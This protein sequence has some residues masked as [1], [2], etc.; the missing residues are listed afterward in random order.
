MCT[1]FLSCDYCVV[2]DCS[3][4]LEFWRKRGSE[5]IVWSMGEEE[6][7]EFQKTVKLPVIVDISP[8]DQ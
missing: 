1:L 8:L 6:A 7:H 4:R 5:V 3:D 2:C